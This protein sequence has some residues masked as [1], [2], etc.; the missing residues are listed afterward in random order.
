MDGLS[1]GFRIGYNRHTPLSSAASN[2]HSANLHP[3]VI[4][5]YLQKEVS[6]QRMLSPFP[7]SFTAPELHLNRFGVIPKGHNTGKWRVIT[8]LSFP[9]GRSVN[10]GVAP[11]LC[12]LT[13]TTVDHVAEI[14]A[15]LGRAALLAKIDIE[16]AFRLVPVHPHDHALQAMQ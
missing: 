1:Y 11:E 4:T 5:G 8:D 6:L 12:S 3:E 14:V 10:D 9:P 15:S 16:S 7:I 13:Y 2:M